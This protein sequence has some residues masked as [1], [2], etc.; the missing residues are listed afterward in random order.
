[1][2]LLPAAI[3]GTCTELADCKDGQR[4]PQEGEGDSSAGSVDTLYDDLPHHSPDGHRTH[5]RDIHR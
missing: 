4:D 1:M 2:T 5:A 3:A